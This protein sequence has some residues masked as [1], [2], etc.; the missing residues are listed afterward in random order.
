MS[1]GS[2][3]KIAT[4][5]GTEYDEMQHNFAP[6]KNPSAFRPMDFIFL[7]ELLKIKRLNLL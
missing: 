1:R 3:Y 2:A 4:D 6:K 7:N 5:S